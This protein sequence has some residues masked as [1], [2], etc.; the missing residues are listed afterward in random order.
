MSNTK[1]QL[2]K[3]GVSGNVPADLQYGEPALNYDDGRLY[4]KSRD[5]S[6][7]Y[8]SS[9]DS[10]NT[11]NVNSTLLFAT[12]NTDI[13]SINPAFG[14]SIIGSGK[15]I[16]I[17]DGATSNIAQGA[18]DHSNTRFS[19]NGGTLYGNIDVLGYAN[20]QNT[21]VV[22]TGSYTILPN[23]IAQFTGNTELYSQVNQQNI[24]ANG[25]ADFVVT[26]DNGTDEI[27]YLDMGIA[28]ST[29][30]NTNYNSWQFVN[31]ND[32]Y[33]LMQGN[34]SQNFG[35]NVFIGTSGSGSGGNQIGDIVFVQG[36]DTDNEVARFVLHEGLVVKTKTA[37]TSNSSGALVVH[38][39]IGANG[40]IYG[41]AVYDS[42]IR[43]L[44]RA[45]AANSKA[46]AAY[47]Y[48]NTI[49]AGTVDQTAR[50]T[51]NGAFDTANTDAN[52]IVI[53]A[54]YANS[55]YT[56]ANSAN[57][58][59][60]AAFDYANTL[61]SSSIDQTARD[62]ANGAFDTANTDANNITIV[63]SYANSA[64][65]KSNTNADDIV[66]T[67]SYTNSAFTQA[68]SA[69]LTA[70]SSFDKANTN[71]DN[72]TIVASYAN[73]AYTAANLAQSYSNSSFTKSNTNA[74]DIT[75]VG[76]YANS[77][78]TQANSANSTAQAAFDKAN[79]DYTNVSIAGS[80]ANS[81]YTLANTNADNITIVGSYANS[82]FTQANGANLTAQA[83]FDK[84]N[85]GSVDIT[86]AASYANSAYTA[87]NLAQSYANS[88][89][90]KSNTNATDITIA[91][92]YANSAYTAANLAQSYANS[93]YT[94]SNTNATDITI[95]ASYANGAY[96]QANTGNVKAQAAFDKANTDSD[97]ITI[98][99]SY[100]NSAYTAA[101]LAQSYSNSA[102]TKSNTNA[103]DITIVASYAN[104]AFTKSNTNATDI[105][106]VASYANSAYTAANLAQSYANSAFTKSNTNATDITI[107]ASYA[108]SSYTQANSAN[109]T[110]QAAFNKANT[111]ATDITIV[112]SYANS[113]YTAA[114]LAQS[115]SNSAYTNSNTNATDITIVGSYANSAYT[116]ANSKTKTYV[117]SSAPGSANVNDIWIDSLTGIEYTYISSNSASQW[118]EFGPY[119]TPL[120]G[121][122]NIQ[123]ADQTIFTVKSNEDLVLLSSGAS[124][125]LNAANTIATGN[126]LPTTTSTQSLGSR[127]L[128]WGDLWIGP[129]TLNITDVTT[130]NNA[131]LTVANGVLLI[132][133][134]NQLQVGQLR[135]V[136]NTIESNTGNIN[137]QIGLTESTANL[138]LNRNVITAAG[139]TITASG[140]VAVGNLIVTGTSNLGSNTN[141]KITGGTTGQT[142]TTDGSGNLSWVNGTTI[143]PTYGQFWSNTT[144]T[145]AV[146]DTEYRFTFNNSDGSNNVQ[147][148]SGAANSRIIINKTGLYNIQFSIQIDK[149]GGGNTTAY[150]WFK[151]NG[152]AI[153][154]SGGFFTLDA[155]IQVVQSWNILANVTSVGDY[156]EIAYAGSDT[157][158][159]FPNLAGN[160]TIGYPASPSIIVTVTP[161]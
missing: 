107:T 85:T 40:S 101:N 11:I 60:Q 68:N 8:I 157:N 161:V 29:Y 148:G 137:I 72:I 147:R 36:S 79:T 28:G 15:T 33:L 100:A 82:A 83:S 78:Y 17:G 94:K 21:I 144:Q 9:T 7:G 18:F 136:N 6:I 22:G 159:V 51:A 102:F 134:A 160:P 153:A 128:R 111:N 156:Y 77:A 150:V 99:G 62:T 50:D 116:N 69:N 155:T 122:A 145:I 38:G 139:K 37:S 58:T 39:G 45:N 152:T 109:A 5:G 71:A 106:I 70:Q 41:D 95:V 123:F 97:N 117:Q 10:F 143:T 73:S 141:I 35:G 88:A 25:T 126:F 87:A 92:S 133:G 132:Q 63:A 47:D 74:T 158:F 154:D 96:T 3:S 131:A 124:I 135:F 66:I 81:A 67:A 53:V 34:A 76:S 75:I 48:A 110:A 138:V 120:N 151:K 98:T 142:L 46:Q 146:K 30:N 44:D 2:K 121:T 64:F 115:Y 31:P 140:N 112:A 1:I 127:T 26:A 84:A 14:I 42:N 56:Q 104:S 57:V 13:L 61:N 103:T 4:Y 20:V 54:S 130:G 59:A 119:G 55:A 149:T 105:T 12:S 23:L 16:T 52:N 19:A 91:A 90:T 27:N 86:I 43:I 24:N 93:A 80:Y 65:T 113:S 129:N 125:K 118:I 108:N 32:G 89:Y 49:G 114:N